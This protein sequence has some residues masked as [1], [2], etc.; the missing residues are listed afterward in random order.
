MLDFLVVGLIVLEFLDLEVIGI[1]V[2]VGVD[3]KS[4]LLFGFIIKN[5]VR[6]EL[7]WMCKIIEYLIK[8]KN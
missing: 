5:M 7:N 6:I 8:I 1:L 3:F 4:F 2:V